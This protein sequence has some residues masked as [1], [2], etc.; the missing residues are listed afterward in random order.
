MQCN[1]IGIS[2]ID[3][4][5]EIGHQIGNYYFFV[6]EDGIFNWYDLEGNYVEDPGILK[7]INERHIPKNITKCVIPDSVESID[8]YT[9]SNCESLTS[10]SI[11]NSVARIFNNAFYGCDSLKEVIFKG[12]T[13]EKVKKMNNYPFGIEDESI[14]KCEI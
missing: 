9:F 8:E 13:L 7:E 5:K 10:I 1:L 3:V 2:K 14:F 6:S 11:P 4:L 12:K